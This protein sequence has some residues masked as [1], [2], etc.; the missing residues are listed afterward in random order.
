MNPNINYSVK[1]IG[2]APLNDNWAGT[3][4]NFKPGM[5]YSVNSSQ[6]AT[7]IAQTG[8]FVDAASL[9]G[10][11]YVDGRKILGTPT[12]DTALPGVI[13]EYLSASVA[14]ASA[15]SLTT[16]TPADVTSLTLTPGEWDVS[17]EV[18]FT[19]GATTS[20]TL[21]V[22]GIATTSATIGAMGTYA[23]WATAANVP[24]A[25]NDNVISTPVVRIAVAAGS[26][27]TVYLEANAVFTVST[28][29]AYGN[30]RARRVR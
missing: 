10:A 21:L 23:Q 27:Q 22:A 5:T 16:A 6:Y 29:K 1:F 30:I 26:T 11:G 25:A 24:T 19:L 9:F 4:F 28:A 17:G 2:T 8:Y 18:G 12:N 14:S 15:V 20:I 13:G 7:L 3:G